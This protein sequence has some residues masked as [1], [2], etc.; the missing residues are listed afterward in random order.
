MAHDQTSFRLEPGFNLMYDPEDQDWALWE[1]LNDGDHR[2]IS[3][4][5]KVNAAPVPV[6][7]GDWSAS[8]LAERCRL[9]R[10][11][12]LQVDQLMMAATHMPGTRW[13]AFCERLAK[14]MPQTK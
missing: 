6:F 5:G 2:R 14:T 13:F 10:P 3:W 7:A 8:G 12:P 4:A 1:S 11:T 9:Y